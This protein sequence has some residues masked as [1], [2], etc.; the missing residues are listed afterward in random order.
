[1][2]KPVP[3]AARPL[4]F[5]ED[6]ST[7]DA[8]LRLAAAVGVQ[9]ELAGPGSGLT[10]WGDPP[11][12][13]VGTDQARRLARSRPLRRSGVAIVGHD[14]GDPAIWRHAVDLGAER[15]AVLPGDESWLVEVLADI[16]DGTGAHATV[17]G[18]IGGRGG[19]GASVLA[20]GLAMSACQRGC[21]TILVDA[22]PL[23]GGL[24]LVLGAE[25][26]HGLR[27]P[28]LAN[29]R[30]RLSGS[31]LRDQLPQLHG[32]TLV[33]WDRGDV[34]RVSPEA[35]RAVLGASVRSWELVVI[36]LPRTIDVA[37]KEALERCDTVLVVEMFTTAPLVFFTTSTVTVRRP[38]SNNSI[39]PVHSV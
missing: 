17:V 4:L 30:G 37:A 34:V 31:T 24:D 22:D 8:V 28:D 33:S 5:T 32:L 20:T 6:E 2:S 26:T 12:I 25:N 7:L 18:V 23:G 27:W 13:L 16:A 15:V 29:T 3:A 38:T 11:L 21:S 19:A 1:M 9:I 10:G 14:S 36:D 39:C 35:V